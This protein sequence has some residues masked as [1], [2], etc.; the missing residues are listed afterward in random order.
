MKPF[1]ENDTLDALF[2]ID[3]RLATMP[4]KAAMICTSLDHVEHKIVGL[5]LYGVFF[6]NKKREIEG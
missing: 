1:Q 3:H 2:V 5:L 4:D 6:Q